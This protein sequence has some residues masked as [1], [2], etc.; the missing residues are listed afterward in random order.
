MEEQIKKLHSEG[1]TYRQIEEML[2]CSRSLI[3]YY[4]NPDGKI[5]NSARKNKN[6][7]PNGAKCK[8]RRLP[9]WLF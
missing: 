6:S 4:I 9:K 8:V 7:R 2:K 3:S 5:K 1:K